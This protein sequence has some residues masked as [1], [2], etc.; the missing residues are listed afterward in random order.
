MNTFHRNRH[1]QHFYDSTKQS[2]HRLVIPLFMCV[3]PLL[4]MAPS[5]LFAANP[6]EKLSDIQKKLQSTIEEA[7]ETKKKEN[8]VRSNIEN[9]NESIRKKEQELKS[10]DENILKAESKMQNLSEEIR[11]LTE[12]LDAQKKYLRERIRSLYTRQYG[13]D[14]LVLISAQDYQD[15]TKKSKYI[16]LIAFYDSKILN[17][18][19]DDLQHIL[20]KKRELDELNNRLL[21]SKSNALQKKKELQS[22]RNRKDET[23]ERIKNIRLAKEKKI[24]EL[25]ESSRRMQQMIEE[26]NSKKIPDSIIGKGFKAMKGKLPWP[27]QEGTPVQHGEE[28]EQADAEPVRNDGIEI[29]A[30]AESK[31]Q[32]IAGG[33][34]VYAGSFEGYGSL[35][36]IDHGSGYHSLYGNLK[37]FSIKEGELLI[38]GMDVGSIA[39]SKET[40]APVLYFEIR[41][42]G[43]PVNPMHWLKNRPLKHGG[44][45][46]EN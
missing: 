7:Q 2:C 6:L 23:L 17:K 39:D 22:D 5:L 25:E 9:I 35:V 42:R 37:D 31:A 29:Q 12:K 36:I 19:S 41:H 40:A 24:K 45:A 26:M 10:Y 11:I 33:R 32:S 28:S 20:T 16:S 1:I 46:S 27:V 44:Y 13:G 30:G 21:A 43:K 34:V 8:S 3:L 14:A 18:Y 4:F 15:L 38:E